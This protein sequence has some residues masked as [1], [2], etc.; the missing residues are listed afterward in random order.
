MYE[1]KVEYPKTVWSVAE[2]QRRNDEIDKMRQWAYDRFTGHKW[3]RSGH[4]FWF[5]EEEDYA[6]FLLRWA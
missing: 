6:L 1:F 2:I 3:G 4:I 5:T